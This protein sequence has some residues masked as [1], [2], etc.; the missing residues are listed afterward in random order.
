MFDFMSSKPLSIKGEN[1]PCSC[2]KLFSFPGKQSPNF[3]GSLSDSASKQDVA[4]RA[5]SNWF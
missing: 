2:K 1:F 4:K 5:Q 3:P